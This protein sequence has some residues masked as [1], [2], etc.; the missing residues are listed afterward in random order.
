MAKNTSFKGKKPEEL[1]KLLGERR[2]ELRTLRFA[3]AGGRTKDA[4][5]AGK[6]RKDIAR[7]LTEQTAQKNA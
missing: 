6:V 3:N 4:S 2:E 1:V 5:K 7:L